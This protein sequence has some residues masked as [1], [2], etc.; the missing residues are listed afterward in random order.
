MNR[1]PFSV[2]TA[3]AA[4][5][6][7]FFSVAVRTDA[8]Q[9]AVAATCQRTCPDVTRFPAEHAA[10]LAEIAACQTRL[11][12]YDTYMAQLGAGVT[13]RALPQV[14]VDV[15]QRFYPG[16]SLATYRF[17]YSPRQP[18][19][20]TTDCSVAQITELSKALLETI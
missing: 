20:A 7:T 11:G 19:R 6:A 8:A 2:A 13:R 5:A 14:Y 12:L 17:G 10:C 16:A 9:G 15:L 1:G 3:C 4:A 18:A